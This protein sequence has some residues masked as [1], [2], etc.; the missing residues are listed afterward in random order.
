MGILKY[1]SVIFFFFSFLVLSQAQDEEI[2]FTDKTYVDYI[3]TVQL[4]PSN[5]H[6]D[7]IIKLNSGESFL[8]SFDDFSEETRSYVYTIQHCN[9]DWTPSDLSELNYTDGL[10]EGDIE[11]YD[12]SLNTLTPYTRHSLVLPNEEVRWT[13]SGNYILK[14][15]DIED[16]R[17][18]VITRR[19]MIY[20]ETQVFVEL[21]FVSS[22]ENFNTHQE[23]NF[24]LSYNNLRVDNPE[25]E[26]TVILRQNQRW[27]NAIYANRPRSEGKQVLKYNSRGKFS[28]GGGKEFRYVDLRSVEQR[29]HNV[30]QIIERTDTY[31]V[32]LYSDEMRS[33]KSFLRQPDMNGRFVIENSDQANRDANIRSDYADVLFSLNVNQEI[34]NYDVYLSGEFSNWQPDPRY[35]M[36]YN[37]VIHAYLVKPKLKQGVYDYMYTVVPKTGSTK[38]DL[39]ELEGHWYETENDYTILSYYHPFGARYHRLVGYHVYNTIDQNRIN[40]RAS[41]R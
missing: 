12:F 41:N 29:R 24:E 36:V 28:F 33:N 9:A 25:R 17:K 31:D 39:T 40:N 30:S 8:F 32:T 2:E 18:L 6:K 7:P 5:T 14:V 10:T 3:H 13:L 23:V 21:N 15:Y 37:D 26:I 27:D 1:G 38:M 11:E 20:E 35:K 34:E 22:T 4:T 16:E 19:F